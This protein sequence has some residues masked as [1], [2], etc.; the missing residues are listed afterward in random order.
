[1]RRI[2]ISLVL[3]ALLCGGP[4]AAWAQPAWREVAQQQAGG[5]A[6]SNG[7]RQRGRQSSHLISPRQAARRAQRR[8][9]GRVLSVQLEHRGGSPVY[10]V[11]LLSGGVVRVVRVPAAR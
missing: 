10:R 1:M 7:N 2:V 3:S 11:K 5:R 4:A 9:G 8:F 6:D